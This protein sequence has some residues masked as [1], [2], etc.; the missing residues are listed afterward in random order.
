LKAVSLW[1]PYAT[2]MASGA[3]R[4]ETRSWVPRGLKSG[5]LLAIHA[6]KRWTREERELVESDIFFKRFLTTAARR[7][8]W[9]FDTPPLGCFVAIARL[10]H[11]ERTET[12]ISDLV[13]HEEAFGNYG[14]CRYGWIFSEVRPLVPI[15]ARGMQSIFEWSPPANLMY[16]EPR[17][18][19]MKDSN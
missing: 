19:I 13:D 18:S 3:K 1:Q 11:V 12:L 15:P 16:L 9:D 17:N 10:H 14:P 4:I 7:G 8:L 5:D 6:A 2:L